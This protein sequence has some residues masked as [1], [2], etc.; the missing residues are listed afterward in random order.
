MLVIGLTG[1]SGAG[2]GAVSQ[3]FASHGIPVIDAD[4]VYHK[5]LI[6]PSACLCEL[7]NV[8]GSQILATDGTLDRKVLGEIVFSDKAQLARLNEITHRY[9]MATIREHIEAYRMQGKRAVILD[10]PQLFEAGADRDCNRIVSVIADRD[11][12]IERILQRDG[13]TKE[14]AMRRIDSQ[15]S[16]SFFREHSHYL[17]EN[18]G[19]LSA[20]ILSVQK[21]LSEMGV[22]SE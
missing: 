5:L 15:K 8:F 20:L 9:V 2:K 7:V 22:L 16:D 11:I 14:A 4:A 19:D 6:P 13:I 12:R 21:I 10:A 17:I 3:L 18:N 1:P